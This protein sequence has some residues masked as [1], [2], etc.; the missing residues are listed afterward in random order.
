[1]KT[2][3]VVG[4][5]HRFVLAASAALAVGAVVLSA[6]TAPVQPTEE[7]V[8]LQH[9]DVAPVLSEPMVITGS[10]VP[11]I[12]AE[13]F[14]PV[15]T[16][17]QVNL[18]DAGSGTLAE[19]LRT[20]VPG[21]FG[22]AGTELRA[23]GGTG[24]AK[25]NLRGLG[26]T[27]TLLDGQRSVFDELNLIPTI[28]VQGV[29]IAKDGASARYGADA[30]TGVF[31]TVL[32]PS[33]R[34]AKVRAYYGNTTGD[35]MGTVRVGFIA[36][37]AAGKTDVVVAGEYYHR[38]AVMSRDRV[39]SADADARSQGGQNWREFV[40]SGLTYA[41]HASDGWQYR[42]L[43]PGRTA[44][45]GLS[46]FMVQTTAQYYNPRADTALIPE[47]ENKSVYARINH[48]ILPGGRLEAFAR[49]LFAQNEYESAVSP[50]AINA[51]NVTQYPAVSP[52]LPPVSS[53]LTVYYPP[54]YYYYLR[55][56]SIG[57]R[58][59]I[60]ERDVYDFQAG[61]KGKI[62]GGWSWEA[63]YL[64][65][66]WYRDDTQ[67][68]SFDYAKLAAAI[69][70]GAYNPYALDSARGVNPTNSRAFDNPAALRDAAVQGRIDHDFGMRGGSVRAGGPVFELP[71]GKVQLAVGGDYT[72]SEQSVV[73]DRNI[74]G[75]NGLMIGFNPAGFTASG[76]EA[77]GVFAEVMVPLISSAQGITAVRDLRLSASVRRS[78]KDVKGAVRDLAGVYQQ[79]SREFSETTP[80]V[81]VLYRPVR[82]VMF[83]ATYAEGFRTP[84][85]GHLFA[86]AGSS[87]LAL[88]DPLGFTTASA[89]IVNSR[90]NPDLEPE[91][92]KTWNVGAVYTPK[93]AKG[94]RFE[95]DY[96]RGV[97]SNLI[98]D[99]AQYALNANALTQGPGFRRGV[100]GSINPNAAFASAITRNS[101]GAVTAVS[102]YPVNASSREASGIDGQIVAEWPVTAAKV[103]SVLA[104]NTTLN[105]DLTTVGG[106]PSQNWLGRYVDASTNSIS[107]GS[108]PRHRGRFSQGVEKGAWS[109]IGAVNRV[110]HLED[111]ATRTLGNRPRY[112]SQWT[113]FD[114]Q[115]GYR[116]K[117]AGIEVRAGV[118]NIADEAA[119]FA[120]GAVNA[121]SNASYDVTLH[122]DIGRFVYV[123]V[124]KA[125]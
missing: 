95:V 62:P 15:T 51:I 20:L 115:L 17:S 121:V 111:D 52:H 2:S 49:M 58:G 37:A 78:E 57:P 27:L 3:P 100:A 56:A 116:W 77:R 23:N 38:N 54:G 87:Q 30:L 99:G 112:V 16:I 18:E 70:S 74:T 91:E 105:W 4:S 125:F 13:A 36:G 110:S 68:N 86:A 81:G 44:G 22:E 10:A 71:A 32:V 33:Y 31:N 67:T 120:A 61:L 73:P 89:V 83:R 79:R 24:V 84:S 19:G 9:V 97:V 28:A 7:R 1:M 60:Y 40:T 93:A 118:N 114:A 14:Q 26:G 104:W 64:Y 119:P 5:A 80:K 88:S 47:Q 35:D 108:I 11:V 82:D 122:N 103:M 46:D 34:G 92:S 96:Y 117:A 45:Y 6:Q 59:R 48:Q 72:L 42:V 66:W 106:Q 41:Y 75:Q 124:T 101:A 123:Q 94:L 63:T 8:V 65:S 90:G 76:Y 102:F 29:E 25:A 69:N 39:G 50:L 107:P 43:A 55:P 113:T 85:L 109:V 21:F 53:G 12:P 98:A